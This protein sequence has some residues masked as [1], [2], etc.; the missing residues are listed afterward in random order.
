MRIAVEGC[1]HGELDQ[2]YQKVLARESQDG[3]FFDVLLL[4]GDF[5]A[6][7]NHAD[8]H[9]IAV[10]DKYRQLGDFWQYYAGVKRAPLLTLVIGG[11]HEASNYMHELYYGGWLA[12]NIYF[13]GQAGCVEVG[14]L[15]ISG[16]SGIYK[17]H[18]YFRGRYEA[19]PY[20]KSDLRSVYHTR[21]YDIARLKLLPKTDIVLSHDWPN[22]IELHGDTQ[23]LI[24]QKPFFADEI[25]T[26]T[27]GSPP[28]LE[29]LQAL[30]PS[31]WCSAH[32]HVRF[33]ATFHHGQAHLDPTSVPASSLP[34]SSYPGP[35]ID[36]AMADPNQI[37]ID[38]FD[39][40]DI[41]GAPVSADLSGKTTT[42][43]SALTGEPVV[44]DF[45]DSEEPLVPVKE[46]GTAPSFASSAPA[47]TGDESKS[48]AATEQS[49]AT[50]EN[51]CTTFLAL[52]KCAK[53]QTFL[54]FFDISRNTSGEINLSATKR[55]ESAADIHTQ[56]RPLPTFRF[57][58][59]WLNIVRALHPWLSL[60][61][62]QPPL[63]PVQ[64]LAAKVAEAEVWQQAQLTS[65]VSDG[66]HHPLDVAR[67]QRFVP[68]APP[69]P[70][71]SL[72]MKK[73]DLRRI[74]PSPPYINPQTVAFCAFV[75]IDLRINVPLQVP[76]QLLNTSQLPE[77]PRMPDPTPEASV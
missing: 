71:E 67:V 63:P 13:L 18:D 76:P 6:I 59:P 3:A 10:P 21:V 41:D 43:P 24:K 74:P 36:A 50:K 42:D 12:P 19:Q 37:S 73:L 34:G 23:K 58:L 28:L 72:R 49:T 40:D 44:N 55:A 75:G 15:I 60:T 57:H 47:E 68:T 53:Y 31:F 27:L 4:C 69:P 77:F 51:R 32:L 66:G 25:R 70:P 64:E 62:Q 38:D 39:D 54:E 29:L 30:K 5:Q 16:I 61:V 20:N 46:S 48:S 11:N 9:S 1:S 8:L 65:E 22:T 7:R 35:G 45:G 26:H 14:D 52:G 17:K 33:D 56:E 2:I